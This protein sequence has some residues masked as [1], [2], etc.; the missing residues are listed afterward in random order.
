MRDLV[1]V[2]G[3]P[4]GLSAAILAAQNGLSVSIIEQ[5][6]GVIDK[7]CGEGLMPAA[8]TE[9]NSMGVF[10]EQSH[11]FKGIRYIEGTQAAEGTF[12]Q[13]VG[14]G[15]RRLALHEAL[16]KRA[17]ELGVERIHE[18]VSQFSQTETHVNVNDYQARYLFAADGLYSSIRKKLNLNLPHKRPL[19]LGLRRHYRQKPWSPFVE[20]YWSPFAEAY[21]TPVADD[22]IGVAILYYKDKAP[23]SQ[24]KYEE[25]LAR[26]PTLQEKLH[27][28]CTSLRGSG[29]FEQRVKS[30]VS[31]RILL[32]GDAA[33]YLD[34]LTGEGIRLGLDSAKAAVQCIVADQPERYDKAW[35]KVSR[36]YWWMTDGLLKLR[37]VPPLR[38]L[39][40]PVLQRA[41][42]LFRSIVSTLAEA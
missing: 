19:R 20:V 1:I 18:R 17:E 33:G 24:N 9:L 26:F 8:V 14:L 35:K 38:K 15:V 42:W 36:R 37:A 28:P 21:V 27:T 32:V 5:K 29:P 16:Q 12:R 40:I 11:I 2:G 4:S 13:G 31:G 34:P 39:M 22:L 6:R 30:R 25:L 41:P 3:G 7:A 10:P 23:P